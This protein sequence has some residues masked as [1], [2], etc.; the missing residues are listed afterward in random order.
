MAV[1]ILAVPVWET[2]TGPA[3]LVGSTQPTPETVG[4]L[5]SFL[6]GDRAIVAGAWAPWRVVAG[7]YLGHSSYVGPVLVAVCAVVAVRRWKADPLVRAAAV[8]AAGAWV[9]QLG[10]HLTLTAHPTPVPLPF[11][12]LAHLPVLEDIIPSR[13]SQFVGL[14]V[15]AL[16]A[17]AVEGIAA[18]WRAGW[19]ERRRAAREA[20]A[21]G[22]G[23]SG[24]LTR[25]IAAALVVVV[26]IVLAAPDQG[27]GAHGIGPARAFAA[28]TAGRAGGGTGPA[29]L[30]PR[31]A[32]VL[33]YPV[34]AFPDDQA[35]LWQ[36]VGD[37]RFCLV[38]GYA[39]RPGPGRRTDR[40]PLLP[41]PA[42]L[43]RALVEAY[44]HPTA[45]RPGSTQWDGAVRSLPAFVVRNR[46]GA[47]VVEQGVS[48]SGEVDALLRS[49]LGPPAYRRGALAVWATGRGGAGIVAGCTKS[50]TTGP[51]GRRTVRGPD[52]ALRPRAG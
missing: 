16:V 22:G 24:K 43:P 41:A 21:A 19:E 9:L 26:G 1:P 38:G 52:R 12:L 42:A 28:T 31:G 32:V 47:V 48:G 14:G 23:A 35:M 34:P 30:V 46:V 15:G 6:P 11:D 33:A 2:L 7:Q 40:L 18:D 20:A 25:A 17:V 37:L 5:G 49:V 45:L 29:G 13:F 8:L 4:L 39:I 51:G 44:H 3:R 10:G 36:A 27:Y 50:P